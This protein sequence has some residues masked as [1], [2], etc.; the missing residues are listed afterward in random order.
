MPELEDE[1][2]YEAHADFCSV[3]ANANRLKILD[4]LKNG[5]Q[6]SVS[7]IERHTGISQSTVSQHLK[8]MRDRGIVTRERDGVNNYYAVADDRIV[9]GVETIREVVKEQVEN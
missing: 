5:E 7:D 1:R 3:C 9:E 2:F 8:L 6:Y 4:L